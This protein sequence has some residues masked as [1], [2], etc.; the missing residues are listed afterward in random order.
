MFWEFSSAVLLLLLFFPVLMKYSGAQTI[1][2]DV[3]SHS[4]I[5]SVLS[6][7][8]PDK[9]TLNSIRDTFYCLLKHFYNELS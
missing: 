8:T 2:V 9:C 1:C 3:N 6:S 7:Y 5:I 4:L